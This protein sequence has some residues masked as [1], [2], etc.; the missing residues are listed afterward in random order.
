MECSTASLR[1][2]TSLRRRSADAPPA[3]VECGPC[4]M[5]RWLLVA[6]FAFASASLLL[7]CA[8]ARSVGSPPAIGSPPAP[9]SQRGRVWVVIVNGG[10][11]VARNY[12]SHVL[13]VRRLLDLLAAAG[14]PSDHIAIFASD[15]P[16]P[17]PDLT[18]RE[19]SPAGDFWLLEGTRLEQRLGAPQAQ[20][21]TQLPGFDWHPATRAALHEWFDRARGELRDGD[22]L[23]FYVTDHGTE[24]QKDHLDNRIT[25][26]GQDESLS[27]RE[28]GE[29]VAG[30][31]RGVR[32]VALMSECF[33][34]AF[35]RL[36]LP[37]ETAASGHEWCGFFSSTEDRRAY[38]CYPEDR[39][40]EN[41]GHSFAF[42]AALA[43]SGSFARAHAGTLLA[44]RTPDVPLRTSD[45]FLD[46]LLRR[47]SAGRGLTMDRLV[48]ELLQFAWNDRSA[49][50]PEIRLLDS[51][52]QAFG[53]FSPRSLA[54]LETLDA[55]FPDLLSKTKGFAKAW[56][57][58]LDDRRDANVSR[59]LTVHPEWAE[60]V[61][62]STPAVT[63]VASLREGLLQELVPFTRSDRATFERLAI[64]REK[65]DGAAPLRYR[66]E[67]REAALLRMR[68]LLENVAGRVLLS[69]PST[70]PETRA[71]FAALQSCEDFRLPGLLPGEAPRGDEPFPSYA[72]DLQLVERMLPAWLGIRFR[73]ADEKLRS[74]LGLPAGAVGV[75]DVVAGS[76]AERAG[77]RAGD[78]VLGTPDHAFE[79]KT[80][81]REWTMLQPVGER[82]S[83]LVL[84]GAKRR[85]ISIVAAPYQL[86][87]PQLKGPP[88]LADA[89]PPLHLTP[90]RGEPPAEG[91][92]LLLFFWATWCLP[93]KAALPEVLAFERERGIPIIAITDEPAAKLDEFF[94]SHKQPFPAVV[95]RDPERRTTRDYGVSGTPTFVL[96]DEHGVVRSFH[97]GYSRNSGGLGIEGWRH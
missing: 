22:Q 48:D 84:R 61:D 31:P 14:T 37:D 68:W 80:E 55:S 26:W 3:A 69:S 89:A 75:E 79:R 81:I 21:S 27:V 56:K 66:M 23:L 28:L 24:N 13:H 44:D 50:E 71:R 15:G 60:R 72:D 70:S 85:K 88:K 54:E 94:A 19:R 34:G 11:S 40:R 90:Y 29:L 12:Q 6:F 20:I 87:A 97:T 51:L 73:S 9:L 45:V 18:V 35:A 4:V 49:W 74:A 52:G 58:A 47:E 42:L 1:G 5:P 76:P 86:Q 25:L 78:I 96:L 77:L 16:D 33:S 63:D 46:D 8:G 7:G 10:A 39:D 64:L 83:L 59:F 82:R 36:A 30:L 41:V 93:C 2:A 65:A 91:R 67:V 43:A 92:P 38:G 32:V 53:W 57:D 62:A 95:A 17:A